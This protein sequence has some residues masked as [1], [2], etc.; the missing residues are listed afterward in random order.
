MIR[1]E[2]E[3]IESI[4]NGNP[5]SF[6]MVFNTY[7]KRLCTFA[8]DYTRQLEIAEDIVK[9]FFVVFWN[10]REKLEITTS[11]SGY[12]FRSVR[13]ACINYLLRNKERNKTISIEEVNWVEIKINEPLSN[14]YPLGNLLAKEQENQIFNAI[15]KLPE[16]C[17]EVFKLSRFENLSHKEIAERLNISKNTVKVQVFRALKSLKAAMTSDSIILFQL[18]LKK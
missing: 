18:F 3:L 13:N 5:K 1:L 9:D 8:F 14:D 2:R 6:E 7:Y 10:N 17:R 15:E 12:L 11:L 4:K 16:R